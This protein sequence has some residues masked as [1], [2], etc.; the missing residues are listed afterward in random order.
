MPVLIDRP[1]EQQESV[2]ADHGTATTE[3]AATAQEISAT[4]REL[5][6]TMQ[7][8]RE[9]SSDTERLA[10][11]SRAGLA[12]MTD[13]MRELDE[14]TD[15]IHHGLGLIDRKSDNITGVL[16]T[17]TKIAAH[18]NLLSLNAAIEAEKAGEHGLGF[19]VVAREIRRLAEQT[20]VA[21][22]EIEKMVTDMRQAVS[23]GVAAMET[24]TGNVK[25]G[26]TSSGE[27][28]GHLV[29]IIEQVKEVAPRFDAAN[30][31]MQAQAQGAQQISDAMQDLR[32]GAR[33]TSESIGQFK[34]GAEHLRQVSQDLRDQISR[35]RV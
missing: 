28:S 20:A 3:V 10:D 1:N 24:F 2:V 25:R 17:I 6:R 22:L 15:S 35:F 4:S 27:L 30:E 23:T 7:G 33:K 8:V 26:V 31:G 12:E 29:R 5:V 18:T 11:A 21:T 34:A 19:S 32:D 16:T 13:T 14:A 9:T